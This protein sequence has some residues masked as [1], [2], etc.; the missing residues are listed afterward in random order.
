VRG[1]RSILSRLLA[2]ID[3]PVVTAEK[4]L[5]GGLPASDLGALLDSE[6]KK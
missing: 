3:A 4:G 2:G 5:A 6:A 1:A